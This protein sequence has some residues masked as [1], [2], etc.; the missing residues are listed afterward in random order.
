[1]AHTCRTCS[2]INP[3]EAL[4]CYH[5]GTALDGHGGRGRPIQAGAQPFRHAF[6]FPSGTSC[7]NFDELVL[8]CQQNWEAACQM[9]QQGYLE[10]FLGGM[11]RADLALAARE[12]ARSPDQDRSLDDFLA[13]LPSKLL[14][15]ADLHVEPVQINLGVLSLGQDRH[16]E[17]RLRNQGM[18]LL[19]GTATCAD[20]IWLTVGDAPGGPRKLFQFGHDLVIPVHVIGRRLRAA[21]KPLE[22]KLLVESNGGTATVVVRA[23]V[24]V[25]PFPEG[26][27]AGAVSPR[28]VA[29]K[30]KEAPRDAVQ[31]FENGAVERWY[32]DN[33]WTYPV[34]GPAA[35][36]LSAVQQ[37]FEALGLTTP[38]KV[39]ISERAIHLRGFPGDR[40]EHVLKV[41][42]EE[43]RPVYASATS[44][45]PWLKIGRIAL[46]GRSATISVE[47]PS[48]PAK[49]GER[50]HGRITVTSNGNQRFWVAVMLFVG[51]RPPANRSA[52][53]A[54]TPIQEPLPAA[55]I[56]TLEPARPAPILSE[57]IAPIPYATVA[58]EPKTT[59][60]APVAKRVTSVTKPSGGSKWVH[61]VPVALLLLV[62]LGV[63]TRDFLL[64][65]DE[66]AA[67]AADE[68]LLDLQPRIEVLFHDSRKD[69]KADEAFEHIP[70]MRFGLVMRGEEDPHDKT[71]FKRLTYDEFGRSNNTCI[72]VDGVDRIFGEPKQGSWK[73][74]EAKLQGDGTAKHA[75][76]RNRSG[77]HRKR[78]PSSNMS[79][80]SPA[81]RAVCW[82][83][84]ASATSSSI[85]TKRS[86]R[87]VSASYSTR[88]SAPTTACPSRFP[89]KPACAIPRWN[90]RRKRLCPTSSRRWRKTTCKS[91][92]L[93]PT[94]GSSLAAGLKCRIALRWA[95]G[96]TSSSRSSA[97]RRQ[98]RSGPGGTCPSWRSAGWTS[99]CGPVT[100]G[101]IPTLPW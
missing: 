53:R 65:G 18:R 99:W 62:L 23:E 69:D 93:S 27:L 60:G 16:F 55:A 68:G 91:P 49:P 24:P 30:A 66:P 76:A 81:S 61:L 33:G 80:S 3:A 7:H 47:V 94:S 82:I 6:V 15:P 50:L 85:R 92:E 45:Q 34:Q 41:E 77:R 57:A 14:Q 5:D 88:L 40:L 74:R 32:K 98:C 17:L 2:R 48:V 96:P 42:T 46:E 36:G 72:R 83:R 79:R 71:K 58:P 73:E 11:G 29:E 20:S 63:V 12:A 13:K 28:Q 89:D 1:M 43:K 97:T 39:D 37:F 95:P 54:A 78:S 64:P 90:S 87:S 51:D 8:T 67:A 56:P 19:H 4:Y 75:T 70:S 84:A 31:L 38:P 100:T 22:G 86:I 59:N 10:R 26:V 21:S 44:D 52:V 9:L 35:S 101:R 25:K